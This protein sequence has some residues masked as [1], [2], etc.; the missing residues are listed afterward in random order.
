MKYYF[1]LLLLF[2]SYLA[3]AQ[4]YYYYK[5]KKVSIS[6]DSMKCTIIR[7]GDLPLLR[8]DRGKE[9]ISW[10]ILNKRSAFANMK[11]SD[12]LAIE[13]V[14]ALS[15][16]PVSHL[17]YVKLKSED[18]TLFLKNF[19]EQYGCK[20]ERKV[21]QMPLWY[22]LSTSF[23]SVGNSIE[24]S[25]RCFE[26]GK[27]ADVD[28]GFIFDFRLNCIDEPAWNTNTLW[29]LQAINCCDAWDITKGDSTIIV[30]ILDTGVDQNHIELP[31]V[32]SGYDTVTGEDAK[33][34][35]FGGYPEGDH[36]TKVAGVIAAAQNGEFISGVAPN[37]TLMPISHPLDQ[38]ADITAQYNMPE[39]L[40]N[41]ISWAWRHGAHI[42]NNSWGDAGGAFTSLHSA[43]LKESINEAIE[44]GRDG[45]GT[46]VTFASGNNVAI[47]Y[48]AYINDTIICVGLINESY[49]WEYPYAYG[50]ELDVVAPGMNILTTVPVNQ[51]EFDKGTSL[52]CPHV[53]GLAA[54]MLS[55]NPLL[56][57]EQLQATIDS[58]CFKLDGYG[59]GYTYPYGSW[60]PKTGYGL[61]DAGRAVRAALNLVPSLNVSSIVRYPGNRIGGQI[62][63]EVTGLGIPEICE[64]ELSMPD[65]A[66][67]HIASYDAEWISD[68]CCIINI[69]GDGTMAIPPFDIVVD[70]VLKK[71][72]SKIAGGLEQKKILHTMRVHVPI[73]FSLPRYVLKNNIVEDMVT[74]IHNN[75]GINT[76][77]K[78]VS[79]KIDVEI[80]SLQSKVKTAKIESQI[81][82]NEI[83]VSN[84][85]EGHYVIRIIED[86]NIEFT[87]KFIIKR[88]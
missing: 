7:R 68:D 15:N 56:N 11:Q 77:S 88:H 51:V 69:D 85:P 46:I 40:A 42:I 44:K 38:N 79:K 35:Y 76:Q 23:N 86:G 3:E 21:E 53:S 24:L 43:L 25:N 80:Y 14:I 57:A 37:V 9:N 75:I 83:S 58:T 26:T 30:A 6:V 18:D 66:Q 59:Y 63:L 33:N 62:V 48:P 82:E 41:G 20:I 65:L 61:I 22:V 72:S 16:T 8:D 2:F 28:P 87:D 47:S 17:F 78:T 52:A 54:L 70:C 32:L 71:K 4:T 81:T 49:Q 27:V 12:V 60:N 73:G 13:P 31:R 84:L 10:S 50:P 1:F 39:E 74:V 67:L 64:P 29:N 34:Y 45:L 19:A 55:V 5:G 36:G